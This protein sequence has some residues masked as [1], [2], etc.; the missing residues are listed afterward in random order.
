MDIAV[1]YSSTPEGHA[2]LAAAAENARGS[3]A[4]LAVL[5]LQHEVPS[6]DEAATALRAAL[7]E[8]VRETI[9]TDLPVTMTEIVPTNGADAVSSL[10]DYVAE[11]NPRLLVVGS[12]RRSAVGKL[13]LGREL[14]RI[15]LD[16]TSPILLIK[17]P[18]AT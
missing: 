6:T 18:A 2:A 9:G 7:T 11:Q 8:D 13:L 1:L 12:R 3:N 15:V 14:Q 4:S 10:I 16:V 17:P 5:V